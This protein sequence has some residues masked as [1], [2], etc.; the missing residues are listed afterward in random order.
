M[1]GTVPFIDSGRVPR[2]ALGS[3]APDI[4]NTPP[5]SDSASNAT[6]SSISPK[7]IMFALGEVY[8]NLLTH[9]LEAGAVLMSPCL[10]QSQFLLCWL[11]AESRSLV[12]R[13]SARAILR[14]LLSEL[15][16]FMSRACWEVN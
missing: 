4:L 15:R 16:D 7:A 2:M 3:T 9:S 1:T 14:C 13:I 8:V 12:T 10:L 5:L 6:P 11:T